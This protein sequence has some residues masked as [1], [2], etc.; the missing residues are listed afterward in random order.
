MGWQRNP[1]RKPSHQPP[2]QLA[3]RVP[4][5]CQGDVGNAKR[6]FCE[7]FQQ[8]ADPLCLVPPLFPA[9][10]AAVMSQTSQGAMRAGGEGRRYWILSASCTKIPLG[11]ASTWAVGCP[12]PN[13][14]L[15]DVKSALALES[16]TGSP[17]LRRWSKNQ[18]GGQH[19]A[20]EPGKEALGPLE[21]DLKGVAGPLWPA[22]LEQAA[23]VRAC[24]LLNSLGIHS[25]QFQTACRKWNYQVSS[26]WCQ[27]F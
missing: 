2:L 24:S 10:N 13:R 11:S 22:G 15:T 5:F 6:S 27:T 12:Q 3:C 1:L 8:G 16:R 25:R 7:E 19:R 18:A 14:F 23:A 20:W 17:I 21:A 9:R 4:G 26:L